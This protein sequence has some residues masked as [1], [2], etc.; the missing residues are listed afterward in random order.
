VLTNGA[1]VTVTL[2]SVDRRKS[3]NNEH[4]NAIYSWIEEDWRK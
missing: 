4:V 3:L 1:R 2:E